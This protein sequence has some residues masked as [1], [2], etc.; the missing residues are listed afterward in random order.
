MVSLLEARLACFS[1]PSSGVPFDGR[2]CSLSVAVIEA[3]KSS[4]SYVLPLR[5]HPLRV[6]GGVFSV[7]LASAEKS[8]LGVSSAG[9]LVSSVV[10]GNPN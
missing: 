7:F 1:A 3:Y 10:Q 8:I 2:V 5:N 6:P 4:Y 9:V